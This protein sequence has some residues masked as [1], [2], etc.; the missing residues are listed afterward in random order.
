MKRPTEVIILDFPFLDNEIIVY[1][2][3]NEYLTYHAD[4]DISSNQFFYVLVQQLCDVRSFFSF[5]TSW[6]KWIQP[7]D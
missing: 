2:E 7:E 4:L 1:E 5:V 3:L 6:E